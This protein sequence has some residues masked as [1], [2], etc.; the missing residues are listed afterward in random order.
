MFD[1]FN[2]WSRMMTAGWSMTQ[3]GMRMVETMGAANEVMAARTT[4][5]GSAMRIPLTGDH[6]ELARMVPEKVDAFSRVGSA[7]VAA[8]W[9]AQSAWVGEMQNLG[10][11]AMRGRPP[12]AV[13]LAQLGE[14][15]TARGLESVEAAAQL[16][17]TA[18]APV[19]RKAT[20]NARR[21]KRQAKRRAGIR[22]R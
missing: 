6:R 20:A 14:R 11:M 21:L 22:A 13:E 4:L 17:S 5:I 8:W 10:T 3:T 15:M 7:T 1:V 2:A 9:A 12:T 16:G 19:H 18:L